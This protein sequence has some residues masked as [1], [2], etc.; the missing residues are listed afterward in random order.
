MVSK[1]QAHQRHVG[2]R[3]SAA[4]SGYGELSPVQDE[5]ARKVLD[6][7]PTDVVPTRVLDAGCGHGRLLKLARTRWPAAAL[8]GVDVAAGMIDESRRALTGDAALTLYTADVAAWSHA[9]FDLVVSGSALH[10]LRPFG[11]SLAHVLG[12]VRSGGHAAI[13]FMLEGTLTELHDARRAVAPAKTPSG[14]LPATDDVEAALRAI[15]GIEI[16]RADVEAMVHELPDAATVLR[17]L[18][19]TGVTGGDISR[20][21]APLTRNELRA[22]TEH[23]ARHHA[24]PGGVRVSYVVGYYLLRRA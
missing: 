24:S 6:L 4:A 3:F 5:V 16:L 21:A 17:V 11:P 19:D 1:L 8:T 10:W 23:Y 9:P 15:P 20:G 7:V 13:G 14:R 2:S 12:L 22:L 18:H